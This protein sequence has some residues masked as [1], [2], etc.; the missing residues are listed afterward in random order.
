MKD[1]L[2]GPSLTGS[3]ANRDLAPRELIGLTDG[4]ITELVIDKE[5]E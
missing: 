5:L 2:L 3:V 1:H 4:E